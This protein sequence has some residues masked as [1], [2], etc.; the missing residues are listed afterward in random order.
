MDLMQYENRCG[1]FRH[2]FRERVIDYVDAAG[3]MGVEGLA[4]GRQL[5]TRME[6]R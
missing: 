5:E 2:V 3:R 1:T 4:A 6:T